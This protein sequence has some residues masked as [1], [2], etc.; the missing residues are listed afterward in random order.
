MPH[1]TVFDIVYRPHR[2]ALLKA[3]EA[4]GAR[5]V[6]GIEMLLY[7]GARQFEIWTGMPAPFEE[8]EKA[9]SPSIAP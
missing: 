7:Q 3:A 2:T 1:H 6:F 5:V 8:M 4:R 9:L